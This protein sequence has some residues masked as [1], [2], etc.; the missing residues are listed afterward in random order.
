MPLER[1]DAG[2]VQAEEVVVPDL[3]RLER[4][5]VDL[6]PFERPRGDLL[7]EPPVGEGVV[8]LGQPEAGV[9]QALDPGDVPSDLVQLRWR[10]F[11]PRQFL[12]LQGEV[13]VVGR[14]GGIEQL[15]R[16]AAEADGVPDGEHLVARGD[17]MLLPL[18]ARRLRGDRSPVERRLEFPVVV[19]LRVDLQGR[20]VP[21]VVHAAGRNGEAEGEPLDD[22]GVVRIG[23]EEPLDGHPVFER[24]RRV[25]P[26][27]HRPCGVGDHVAEPFP[28]GCHVQEP[29]D[30]LVISPCQVE[31]AG[32]LRRD[33]T[34]LV[35]LHRPGDRAPRTG[36]VQP[37]IVHDVVE[38]Q[39]LFRL[40]DPDHRAH[41]PE[42]DVIGA[43]PLVVAVVRPVAPDPPV[44]LLPP[45]DDLRLPLV[46][47]GVPGHPLHRIGAPPP[48]PFRGEVV[49][50]AATDRAL[51]TAVH[52]RTVLVEVVGVEGVVPV[53]LLVVLRPHRAEDAAR[54][55]EE[56][57]SDL[58]Q[59]VFD[60]AGRQDLPCEVAVVLLVRRG[61]VRRLSP[62][63]DHDGFQPQGAH[64]RAGAAPGV[65]RLR[66][67]HD[68]GAQDEVLPRA[69]DAGHRH[70]LPFGAGE[71]PFDGPCEV[72]VVHPEI[73]S[74]VVEAD[75][76]AGELE[77]GPA[78]GL[79]VEDEVVDAA[80]LHEGREVIAAVAVEDRVAVGGD[81]REV[82]AGGG[83]KRPREDA[84]AEDHRYLRVERFPAV[85]EKVMQEEHVRAAA[86][87][88]RPQ[89]PDGKVLPEM[90]PPLEVDEEHGALR[91]VL[92]AVV[93]PRRKPHHV[94]PDHFGS[95]AL[96][97]PRIIVLYGVGT[98]A[99]APYS[100]ILPLM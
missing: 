24:L 22:A 70:V 34:A 5:A 74:G 1:R 45:M 37:E 18:V 51:E 54:L 31:P 90:L 9:D 11:L 64:L 66:P 19:D 60:D 78:G 65:D 17:R 15:R 49:Q 50:R 12:Q 48:L 3:Q 28:P 61:K 72:G 68:P 98:P 44:V 30:D 89:H 67:P 27:L 73:G 53:R 39:D 69:G 95:S 91:R 96:T 100:T 84:A 82:A 10:E 40:P 86:G 88:E 35:E 99:W 85:E 38:A 41:F 71:V 97:R 79:A 2:A 21:E 83:G 62:A 94:F 32:L 58:F 57:G 25:P 59:R 77:E 7:L 23:L 42:G 20:P 47:P 4:G 6:L 26:P 80:Q 43:V 87:K 29:F 56:G 36:R 46:V 13:V 16:E 92:W 93:H 81:A 55:V 75:L 52:P 8:L 76:P 14:G 33:D 63:E